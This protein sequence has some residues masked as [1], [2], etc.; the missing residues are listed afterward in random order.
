MVTSS[1]RGVLSVFC[2]VTLVL[3]GCDSFREYEIETELGEAVY[4][5]GARVIFRTAR[6]V[7]TSETNVTEVVE[8]NHTYYTVKYHQTSTDGA[9]FWVD[10][11]KLD[12]KKHPNLSTNP[13]LAAKI[14]LEF[15]FPFYGH[16]ITELFLTTGGFMYLGSYVHRYLA[17]TQ[18]IAPLMANFDPARSPNC[19]IKYYQNATHFIAEWT[20]IQLADNVDAGLFSFQSILSDSG[21]ITFAYKVVP[22]PIESISDKDHP[23]KVGVADAF[24]VD[25]KLT[26]WIKKRTIFEYHK[27]A[28]DTTLV[29]N[30]S[31]IVL[32]PIPTCNLHTDCESCTSSDINFNCTW[33]PGAARCSDGFDRH[34]QTWVNAHCEEEGHY[35][36]VPYN[37]PLPTM[38]PSTTVRKSTMGKH[39]SIYTDCSEGIS[40]HNGGICRY[41]ECLCPTMYTGRL[42]DK[43]I[44]NDNRKGGSMTQTG[45][46][47]GGDSTAVALRVGTILGSIFIAVLVLALVGW[48]VYAYRNPNTNSG[49]FLIDITRFRF[50]KKEENGIGYHY[51]KPGDNDEVDIII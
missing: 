2:I 45:N 35:Q 33:C 38:K 19:S 40:C 14:E 50:K 15:N 9:R 28:L 49:M 46:E 13:R 7:D 16:N 36:E 25:R 32:S 41:G 1:E 4:N 3:S 18:Y 44:G 5:P 30:A 17:A 26:L 43:Y 39:P 51:H 34:R 29:S 6:Q 37:C 48:V 22:I 12:S 8:D 11:T 47:E 24:Y 42:C 20:N 23:M 31:A 10:L 21:H 27:V